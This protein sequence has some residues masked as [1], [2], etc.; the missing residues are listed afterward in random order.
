MREQSIFLTVRGWNFLRGRYWKIVNGSFL[1]MHIDVGIWTWRYDEGRLAC[2]CPSWQGNTTSIC[3]HSV[4][5]WWDWFVKAPDWWRDWERIWLFLLQIPAVFAY[6]SNIVLSRSASDWNHMWR[7]ETS[8]FLV[9][10]G[11]S[12]VVARTNNV[13]L[14]KTAYLRIF[15]PVTACWHCGAIASLV[16]SKSSAS[17]K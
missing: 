1:V 12:L 13:L 16:F 5:A 11:I 9:F 17:T 8:E 2:I 7:I 14:Y 15:T 6:Y 3:F 10:V 4:A